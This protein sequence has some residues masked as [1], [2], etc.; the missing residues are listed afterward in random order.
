MFKTTPI[1]DMYKSRFREPSSH[2]L[3]LRLVGSGSPFISR[4]LE[5]FCRKPLFNIA[6]DLLHLTNLLDLHD[7]E[8]HRIGLTEREYFEDTFAA[9]QN[10]LA[11]FP[12]PHSIFLKS[13]MLY[14]QECFRLAAFIYFN[15]GIR[16]SP[17]PKFLKTMT[18]ALIE[19]F[20]ESDLSSMWQP[21]PDILLW[22]LF[23]GYCGS[24]D[25]LEKGWFV[26]ESRRV[27]RF[28]N[29]KGWR[30]MENLLMLFLYRSCS[31]QELLHT[32]WK[33][34]E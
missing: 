27:I 8:P 23:M 9:C 19:A 3:L 29:L 5:D 12:H 33:E 18:T 32:L 4:K 16:V 24:W 22:I 7:R 17:S 13:V 30:E 15:S 28:L 6:A 2:E 20:Q 26:Q 14:R 25:Q 10:G 11:S 34:F 1:C 21:Y 31:Y